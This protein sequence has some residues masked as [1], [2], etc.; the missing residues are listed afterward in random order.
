MFFV[1]FHRLMW[2]IFLLHSGYSIVS[3]VFYL[4]NHFDNGLCK[5][6]EFRQLQI[7]NAQRKHCEI[8]TTNTETPH[9]TTKNAKW[10]FE[11]EYHFS[12]LQKKPKKQPRLFWTRVCMYMSPNLANNVSLHLL[13]LGHP[14]HW[15][16]NGHDSVSNQQPH[17]CLLNRLFRLRS[18]KTSKLRV[19][20]L[21]A[22]NSPE[23]SEFP[24]Q[25]ASNAENVSIWWRHHA[26]KQ[27]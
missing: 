27:G 21:C 3:R 13:V 4:S 17:D 20:G 2:T 6:A 8:L 15:R 25:M 9:N 11:F 10:Y 26:Q 19:T 23:T 7:P 24:A 5:I 14:L 12:T 1:M 16:H 18:K 22:G